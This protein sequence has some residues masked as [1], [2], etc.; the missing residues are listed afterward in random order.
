MKHELKTAASKLGEAIVTT[1]VG[2]LNATIMGELDKFIDGA[3]A[4][5]DG[6][7]KSCADLADK[8]IDNL[9]D[10]IKAQPSY[11]EGQKVQLMSCET[12]KGTDPYAQKLANE[13]NAPVVAPDKLLWIWPHGAYKPAGQ[14]ADGTMDTADPGVWHTFNPKS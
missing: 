10:V 2:H 6:I 4:K 11:T 5:L 9:V 7:L 14:K 12:G 1:L 13:L 8:I 3:I